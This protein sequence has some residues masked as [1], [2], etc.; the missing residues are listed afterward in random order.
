MTLKSEERSERNGGGEG[1]Q[2]EIIKV[3]P[4]NLLSAEETELLKKGDFFQKKEYH[5]FL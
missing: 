5:K 1:G 3:S 4:P 2:V